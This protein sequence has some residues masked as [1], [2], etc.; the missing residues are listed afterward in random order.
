MSEF[1]VEFIERIERTKS[2]S[3]FRFKPQ[4]LIDFIPGQFVQIFFD[5]KDRANKQLNKYLSF[6]CRPGKAYLEVTKRLSASAFSSRL[7]ALK[8]GDSILFKGPMGH[9]V[10]DQSSQKAAFLIGGI[11]ITPV[12]SILEHVAD[13]KIKV[14][15]RLLYSNMTDEDMAFKEHLDAWAK[16]NENIKVVY[17]VVN[18]VANNCPCFVGMITKDFVISQVPD[19][20]DRAFYL[21]G[22]PAMV[23]A[24]KAICQEIGCAMSKVKAENFLGY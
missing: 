9:C 10:L 16:D 18:R 24:M 21:F 1:R 14:D 17:T 4:G 12:I 2:V 11:G 20:Q 13:K 6:S 8:K 7:L 5:E 15:A 23:N 19:Y 3:S 22:P